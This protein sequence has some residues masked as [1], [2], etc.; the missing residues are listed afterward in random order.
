MNLLYPVLPLR[1]LPRMLGIAVAGA[2]IA[3][4][5]GALHDQVTYSLSEA[6]FT[7]LKFHQF[8]YANF[9]LPAR[10][11]VAVVGFLATWWVGVAAGWVLGRIAVPAW[12]GREAWRRS[13]GPPSRSGH[14]P[15]AA[16]S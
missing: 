12:P 10:G 16:A 2:L 14:S 7:K 3:G 4:T 5:Y 8:H 15:T 11:F 13:A 6:Y 9:G 1:L